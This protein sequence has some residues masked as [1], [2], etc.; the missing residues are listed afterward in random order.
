MV[1][2]DLPSVTMVDT[3]AV[4]KLIQQ[5]LDGHV[6]AIKNLGR[7]LRSGD[8]E[9][10]GLIEFSHFELAISKFG[11]RLESGEASALSDTFS[12]HQGFAYVSFLVA[13]R[14]SMPERRLTVVRK[15]FHG[16]IH[17][18]YWTSLPERSCEQF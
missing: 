16:L 7:Q 11:I 15:T 3:D 1:C 4:V 2:S 6:N 12:T 10:N 8:A 17:G 18:I 14:G 13:V 5:A 9:S